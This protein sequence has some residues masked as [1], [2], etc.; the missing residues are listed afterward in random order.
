MDFPSLLAAA[1]R[2][3]L[4]HLGGAVR[5]VSATGAEVEVRGIFDNA[6]ANVIVQGQEVIS[7]GPKVFLRLEDLPTDPE[8]EP[9]GFPKLVVADVTYFANDV[10]KDGH[11]GVLLGLA[12]AEP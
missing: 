7:S 3:A 8:A 9:K 2:A 1:D 10:S 12:E 6:D 5:Y 11:G 4:A